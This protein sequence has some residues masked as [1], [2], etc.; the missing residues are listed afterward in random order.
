MHRKQPTAIFAVVSAALLASA[1]AGAGAPVGPGTAGSGGGGQ[2]GGGGAG[3]GGSAVGGTGVVQPPASG[4]HL[5]GAPC[6]PSPITVGG[7]PV[8]RISRV[9]YDNMVRD[10][11]LDPGGTQ[12]ARQ[13]V[14]EQKI[15]TG[16]AGN[17]NTN[18]YATISGTL[19]NQQYLQAAE[20][21][22]A[23][24]VTSNL[25][26]LVSCATR[27]AACAQ[28]FITSFAGRAFRG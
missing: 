12:P 10:L 1:C 3:Q 6:Q 17:F 26:G 5:F 8:R 13:F 2:G 22:A 28:Q 7:S 27:N 25:G 16:R 4:L 9:E 18:S 20:A 23:A 19:I 11:G 14:S 24:A 15:D 21:L